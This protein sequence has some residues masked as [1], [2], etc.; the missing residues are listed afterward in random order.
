MSVYLPTIKFMRFSILALSFLQTACYNLSG[1]VFLDKAHCCANSHAQHWCLCPLIQSDMLPII[2]QLIYCALLTFFSSLYQHER[3][4]QLYH[5]LIPCSFLC[6]LLVTAMDAIIIGPFNLRVLAYPYH[7][8][9]LWYVLGSMSDAHIALQECQVVVLMLCRMAFHLSGK[10]VALHLHVCTFKANIC[11]HNSIVLL[12]LYRLPHIE[13]GQQAWYNSHS[14]IH[15]Y[16]TQCGSQLSITGKADC[17]NDI[18]FFTW[19]KCHFNFGVNWRWNCRHPYLPI[20][21][22]DTLDNSINPGSLG[23]L[24]FQPSLEITGALCISFSALIPLFLSKFPHRTWYGSIQMSNSSWIKDP[25]F[26][27]F[28]TWCPTF[29]SGVPLIKS[30]CWGCFSRPGA[31]GFTITTWTLWLL[32]DRLPAVLYRMGKV[33]VLKRVYVTM[34]L[35][36]LN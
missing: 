36:L 20:N 35:L 10:L 9:E 27:L 18:F 19:L 24:C 25:W 28:S 22:S 26:P 6:L 30:I 1:H 2:V 11:N 16:S 34:R 12:F 8:V 14:S 31:K 21:A 23:A 5:C 7:S 15:T 33:S 29:I 4:S 32:G 13:F 3:L 17:K